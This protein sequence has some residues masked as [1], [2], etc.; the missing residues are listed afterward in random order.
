MKKNILVCGNRSFV[1]TNLNEKLI[2]NGLLVDGFTRGKEER[3]FNQVSGDI[4][5]ITKNSFLDKEYDV[6][7][8]FIVLKDKGIEENISYIKSLVELCKVKKVKR[9]IHFS[10]IMVYDNN[11][12]YIDE[13]TEI[14]KNTNKAGY[15]EVKIAID[16]YLMSLTNLPFSISFIRPGYVLANDRPCPFVKTLPLGIT[17]IKGDKKSKQPIVKRDDIHQALV[18]MIQLNSNERVYLFV[19]NHE[20]TKYI[21][22]KEH[23]GGFTLTLPKRLILGVSK[24][25]LKLKLINK[26]LFVR[27]EG[28]YIESNYNS[29][30]TEE[31]LKIKF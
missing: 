25:F 30:K 14:E 20:M 22:A 21:Y 9:L 4:F 24:I 10:S 1:A 28:M 19:P 23:I 2:N 6:V 11:E 7:I 12:P 13:T 8:N 15:G 27:V 16:N 29:K 18:N 31:A 26:S 5:G 3:N 17:I